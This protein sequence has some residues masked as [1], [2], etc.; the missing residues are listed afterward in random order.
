MS[1]VVDVGDALPVGGTA[2]TEPGAAVW[3]TMTWSPGD[4]S[5]RRIEAVLQ[6]DPDDGV[7][8]GDRRGTSEVAHGQE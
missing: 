2:T 4:S 6:G 7:A 1:G 8:C 5:R 3:T